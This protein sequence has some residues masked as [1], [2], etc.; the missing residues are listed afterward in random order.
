MFIKYMIHVQ[1]ILK[2]CCPFKV[3]HIVVMFITVFM[4]YTWLIIQIWYK[5]F[6]NKSMHIK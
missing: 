2:N 4:V 5:S 1:I 3:V 6:S